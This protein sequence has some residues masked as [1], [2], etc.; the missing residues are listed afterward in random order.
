MS[1]EPRISFFS[2]PDIDAIIVGQ[3]WTSYGTEQMLP[4]FRAHKTNFHPTNRTDFQCVRMKEFLRFFL[5]GG[6][7][8][9]NPEMEAILQTICEFENLR[10]T[11]LVGVKHTDFLLG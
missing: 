5:P 1:I 8:T 7:T 2:R 10:E 6:R 3:S 4:E 9:I 11:V